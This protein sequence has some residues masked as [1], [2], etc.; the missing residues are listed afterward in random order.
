MVTL[1]ALQR[2][3]ESNVGEMRK[4]IRTMM[5]QRNKLERI[6]FPQIRAMKERKQRGYYMFAIC[7]W[8]EK[9]VS[10]M[11]QE[12]KKLDREIALTCAW[13]DRVDATLLT[14]AGLRDEGEKRG[15]MTELILEE[16]EKLAFFGREVN[17]VMTADAEA[18]NFSSGSSGDD[19]DEG[20]WWWTLT[21]KCFGFQ[22]PFLR[23]YYWFSFGN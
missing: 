23:V 11:R 16:S 3:V 15:V 2:S 14:K 6:D 17:L 20:T 10:V 8:V 13:Q 7:E 9:R 4:I 19:K 12:A 21:M 22:I 5:K 1:R 18:Y